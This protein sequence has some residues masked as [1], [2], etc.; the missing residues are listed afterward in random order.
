[1][2]LCSELIELKAASNE[3]FQRHIISN[4]SA[5]VR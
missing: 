1:M 4:Y 3:V 5:F 2:H